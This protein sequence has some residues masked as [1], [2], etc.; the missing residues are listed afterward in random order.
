MIRRLRN[1]ALVAIYRARRSRG[2]Q[3]LARFYFAQHNARV[4]ADMEYRLGVVLDQA[5]NG[6]MSK[7]YY[8]V[9]AM[10]QEISEA[11]VEHGSEMY[12]EGRKDA[13]EEHG[14]PSEDDGVPA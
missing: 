13:L 9:E 11:R 14:L 12:R 8:P 5:T 4:L 1:A 7:A 3:W 6:R 2:A 10:L